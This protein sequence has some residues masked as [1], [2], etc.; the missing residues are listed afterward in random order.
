MIRQNLGIQNYK[1]AAKF[2][3]LACVYCTDLQVAC[4]NDRLDEHQQFSQ[5]LT[6][7][8][9]I[10]FANNLE[11]FS[12]MF[13]LWIP[14]PQNI[15]NACRIDKGLTTFIH[16]YLLYTYT[17]ISKGETVKYLY[18]KKT[19]KLY[20]KQTFIVFIK[21]MSVC[22]VYQLTN[23]LEKNTMFSIYHSS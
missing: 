10:C 1:V 16:F 23:T 19:Y 4:M 5:Y 2:R 3:W 8:A 13:V 18:G 6:S 9:T 11:V 14:I 15:A 7:I 22:F 21:W 20:L 17:F 12:Y